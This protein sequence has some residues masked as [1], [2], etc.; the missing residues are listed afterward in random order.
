MINPPP[1]SLLSS[2]P[3]PPRWRRAA[4]SV[5][6]EAGE[7]GRQHAPGVHHLR[8]DHELV[9]HA[10]A[11]LGQPEY[12]QHEHLMVPCDD[13]RP[14]DEEDEEEVG[15]IVRSAPC[16]RQM[17]RHVSHLS[18]SRQASADEA[19]IADLDRLRFTCAIGKMKE[20]RK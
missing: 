20:K 6:G 16:F 1:P 8:H 9:L 7:V 19:Q 4:L 10:H 15:H 17:V 3:P 2:R 11:E 18:Q 13:D 12:E 14:R 5:V